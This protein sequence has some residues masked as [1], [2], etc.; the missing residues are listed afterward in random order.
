MADVVEI[1][2]SLEQYIT[3]QLVLKRSRMK[4]VRKDLL[5]RCLKV[6]AGWRMGGRRRSG[7][8]LL[9]RS[10]SESLLE[11]E[12]RGLR[13]SHDEVEGEGDAGRAIAIASGIG[14]GGM[15]DGSCQRCKKS[16]SMFSY[17]IQWSVSK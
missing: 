12:L 16:L 7:E 10:E 17:D 8:G 15:G 9:L 11:R 5:G 3:V 2:R 4:A 14:L 13:L 6:I 1:S